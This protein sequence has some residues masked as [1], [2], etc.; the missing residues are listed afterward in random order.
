MPEMELSLPAAMVRRL[1][2]EGL[3]RG[4]AWQAVL[5]EFLESVTD[6]QILAVCERLARERGDSEEQIAAMRKRAQEGL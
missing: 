1:R 3:V 4:M 5:N 6:E 2:A